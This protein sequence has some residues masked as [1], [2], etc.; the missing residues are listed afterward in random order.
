M[1]G[2]DATKYQLIIYI[3]HYSLEI[4]RLHLFV[5]ISRFYQ[6]VVRS[7]DTSY[8]LTP[9]FSQLLNK[10][11]LWLGMKKC[12]IKLY[13]LSKKNCLTGFF[14]TAKFL[15]AEWHMEDQTQYLNVSIEIGFNIIFIKCNEQIIIIGHRYSQCI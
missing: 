4:H 12:R 10:Y 8:F 13:I 1:Q 14:N 9:A 11:A 15:D 2:F 3:V 5:S 6:R 7:Y